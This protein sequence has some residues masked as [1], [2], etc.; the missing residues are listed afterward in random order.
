MPKKDELASI[1]IAKNDLKPHGPF[2][3]NWMVFSTPRV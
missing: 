1:V 3:A 2:S